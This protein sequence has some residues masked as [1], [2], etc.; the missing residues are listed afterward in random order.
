MFYDTRTEHREFEDEKYYYYHDD[1]NDEDI[2]YGRINETTYRILHINENRAGT[3][4]VSMQDINNRKVA[5]YINRFKY[6]HTLD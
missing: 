1:E 6:Q 5:V 3:R 2:F 4:F